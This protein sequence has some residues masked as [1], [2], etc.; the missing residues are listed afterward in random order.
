MGAAH[1]LGPDVA[2]QAVLDIVGQAHGLGLVAE[3]DDAGH[4]AE[5]LVLGDL[6]AVVHVGKHRGQHIV[7]LAHALGQ[8][9]RIQAATQH[10]GA[11]LLAQFD[12]VAHLGQVAGADHGADDGGFV[13]RIAHGDLP[14]ALHEAVHELRVD[15]LLHQDAAAGRAALAVVGEDHEHG[16]IQRA[17][18][19]GV[20]KDHEGA[21]AAQ[22]HAEL[23]EA[24]G[25]HDAVAG[26]GRARERD[27]AH[28]A[29]AHQGLARVLA[30]AVH[31]VEHA[32]R[33]ARLQRQLAQARGR[34]GRQLA[35]LEHGRVA[36]GQAG[37]HLPGGRHEGHVPRRDQRAHAH[38]VEQGVVQVR[39]R[40]IGVAVHARAH[41]GK[42]VEVVGRARHQLLSGLGDDLAAVVGLGLRDLG[43]MA[44]DQVA[45]LA[46]KLGAFG[47]GRVGPFREGVL[48]GGD[49]GLHLGLAACSNLGQ[50]L[51]GGG[52]DG[53]EIVLAGDGLAVDQVVNA[54]G[55]SLA[56]AVG[57]RRRPARRRRWC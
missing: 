21:L 8:H 41:L 45:Q 23:L 9:G 14:G 34:H 17:L 32:G 38:G 18:E 53:L 30:V 56:C 35:H 40:G 50:H 28:I 13:Q 55:D 39:G 26:L 1:A 47:G 19:V 27:G 16:R 29:V 11:F 2:G 57:F 22:L 12:V 49:G 43:H 6:H 3:G 4:G 7:A 15:A 25:L 51:L 54:H 10:A 5:D 48:R 46:H 33:N 37:R 20:V 36:E 52:V 24:G 31:Q 42:V 44:G